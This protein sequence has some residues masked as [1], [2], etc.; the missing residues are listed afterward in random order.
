MNWLS[1]IQTQ[2]E[3]ERARSDARA[4]GAARLREARESVDDGAVLSALKDLAVFWYGS[5]PVFGG[6]FGGYKVFRDEERWVLQNGG[7]RVE[8]SVHQ[9]KIG[10]YFWVQNGISVNYAALGEEPNWWGESQFCHSTDLSIDSLKKALREV[11]DN[12]P[13]HW[14][15]EPSS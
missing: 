15:A 11:A 6:L 9:G 12:G 7:K 5:P 3:K 13:L 14:T 2:D 1:G 10:F 4:A 8:V